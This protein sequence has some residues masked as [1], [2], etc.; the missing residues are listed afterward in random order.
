MKAALCVLNLLALI[1]LV[2]FH[3]QSEPTISNQLPSFASQH[4]QHLIP[5]QAV[6]KQDASKQ[7][8]LVSETPIQTQHAGSSERWVF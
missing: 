7:S 4:T 3:F 8:L 2:T 1:A 5:Q 6:M